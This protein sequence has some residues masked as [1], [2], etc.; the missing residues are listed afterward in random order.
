MSLLGLEPSIDAAAGAVVTGE[1]HIFPGEEITWLV[2]QLR[3]NVAIFFFFG[4]FFS[5]E[6]PLQLESVRDI[7]RVLQLRAFVV[8]SL[9]VH[10]Q[11]PRH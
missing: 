3:L 11:H 6:S 8:E 2:A 5:H 9:H 10:D 4:E 1:W 7:D